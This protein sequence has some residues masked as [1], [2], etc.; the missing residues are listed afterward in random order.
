M[1]RLLKKIASRLK[2]KENKEDYKL[3]EE[4]AL[5]EICRFLEH[6]DIDMSRLEV[7]KNT[8]AAGESILNSLV[9]YFRT[10]KLKIE[11]NE[12]DFFVVQTLESGTEIRYREPNAKIKRI[13]DKCDPDENRTKLYMF[14]GAL[15]EKSI[16]LDG[17]DQLNTRDLAV[18]EVLGN[19]FLLA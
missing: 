3:S 13:M 16:G 10:G 15:T 17:I 5:D 18:L 8:E 11:Q 7:T 6:Y 12:K 2:N 1:D 14:M 4:N 9:R 19:L